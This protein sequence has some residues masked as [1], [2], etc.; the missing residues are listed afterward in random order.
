MGGAALRSQVH[1][2][3]ASPFSGQCPALA[4]CVSHSGIEHRGSVLL[5]ETAETR[6]EMPFKWLSAGKLVFWGF[7]L[8]PQ[9]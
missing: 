8:G 3:N 9:L 4:H 5:S 7:L 2:Q 6:L 1:L